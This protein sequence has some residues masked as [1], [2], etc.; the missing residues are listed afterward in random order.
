MSFFNVK[1]LLFCNDDLVRYQIFFHHTI[2]FPVNFANE[3]HFS[4]H[5]HLVL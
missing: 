2:K 4:S 1:N 3:I 5:V